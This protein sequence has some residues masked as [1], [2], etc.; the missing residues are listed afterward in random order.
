MFDISTLIE[1]VQN[2]QG[3]IPEKDRSLVAHR[4][5]GLIADRLKF[6]NMDDYKHWLAGDKFKFLQACG[7]EDIGIPH[8]LKLETTK[9]ADYCTKW[10]TISTFTN[11]KQRPITPEMNSLRVTMIKELQNLALDK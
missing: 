8:D 2:L 5:A 10:M 11:K 6:R 1:F 4:L 3:L 7:L 9:L